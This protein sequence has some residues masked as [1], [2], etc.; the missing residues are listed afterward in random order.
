MYMITVYHEISTRVWDSYDDT[1]SNSYENMT[2]LREHIN[3][4]TPAHKTD[5]DSD[6]SLQ[7]VG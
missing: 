5:R 2:T 6:P 7:G 3:T 1:L 4:E